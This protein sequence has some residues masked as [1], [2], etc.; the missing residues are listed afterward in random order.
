[1][2]FFQQQEK[3]RKN[4]KFLILCFLL[5]VAGTVFSVYSV[6]MLLFLTQE[7]HTSWFNPEVFFPVAAVTLFI[8]TIGSIVKLIELSEGGKAVAQSLGGTKINSFTQDFEEKRLLNIVNEM[9]IAAGIPVPE[10][11]VLTEEDGINAFAAGRSPKDAVIGITRGAIKNLNRD[12]LQGVVAHE[13]SHILNGDMRLNTNLIAAISG[14]LTIS[15]IGYYILR[16]R[17]RGKNSGQIKLIGLALLIIGFCGAF[18]ARIIQSAISR[19]REYLADAS[20]VQFTRN[21]SGIAGALRKIAKMISGSAVRAP[22]TSETAHLFF[23]EPFSGL[24]SA[25]FATHPPIEKRIKAIEGE[26]AY[27]ME[28]Q[29]QPAASTIEEPHHKLQAESLIGFAGTLNPSSINSAGKILASYPKEITAAIENS[30]SAAALV[31]TLLL[32]EDENVREKQVNELSSVVDPAMIDEVRRF[33]PIVKTI[34]REKKLPLVQV[35]IN[36][37]KGMSAQ[38][39]FIFENALDILVRADEQIDLFEFMITKM[40]KRYLEPQYRK[41]KQVEPFFTSFDNLKEECKILLSAIAWSGTSDLKSAQKAY[42]NGMKILG[43]SN[44]NLLKIEQCN[45]GEID[46]ALNNCLLLK[47]LSRERLLN[48]CV[49][50]ASEDKFITAYE[51]ELIRAVADALECPIPLLIE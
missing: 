42:D 28:N 47:P 39:F 49:T 43:F 31:Y 37:L 13:F 20:A 34:P 51:A 11:Y 18:F 30:F 9:A 19:Q 44:E 4:T 6:V 24:L 29:V 36:A 33:Y 21:P 3:A 40:V 38:Q 25:L 8:I 32:D 46:N 22:S 16:L 14:I 10:V 17:M 1:M 15:T 45:I 7:K 50:V 2:N 35:S 26:F 48:A 12:E 27:E 5:G 23:S 41:V